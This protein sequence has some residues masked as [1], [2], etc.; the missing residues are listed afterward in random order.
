[1]AG[2]PR[3]KARVGVGPPLLASGPR[4]GLVL[5]RLPGPGNAQLASDD[6]LWPPSLSGPKQLPPDGLSAKM[7]LM[8]VILAYQP[9]FKKAGPVLLWSVAGFGFCTIAFGLSRSFWFSIAM[10]SILGALDNISVVIRS[11]LVN[12]RTPNH[13]RGRVS[14]VNSVFI[15]CSNEVGGFESGL[16]AKLFGPVVSRTQSATQGVRSRKLRLHSRVPTPT[17]TFLCKESEK[18][19]CCGR[20]TTRVTTGSSFTN[21]L[22]LLAS[23]MRSK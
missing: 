20:K 1:M 13:L 23:G 19:A 2:L 3:S 9:P 4:R 7:L 15:E 21:N 10:L 16:V 14:A 11:V 5:V 8:A 6:K 17:F 22:R 18:S 12:V